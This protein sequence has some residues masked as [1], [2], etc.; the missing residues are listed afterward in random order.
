M[1]RGPLR[2]PPT[3]A[4]R[5]GTALPMPLTTT[6]SPSPSTG[7]GLTGKRATRVLWVHPQRISMALASRQM[8]VGRDDDCALVLAGTEVSRHHAEFRVDGPLVAVRDLGSRNGVFVNGARIADAPLEAGD[9]IRCGEWIGVVVSE[10][11]GAAAFGEITPGWWGGAK[12]AAAVE[13]LRQGKGDLPVIVQGE[14]G[15]GKEGTAHAVHLWSGRKGPFVALNCAALPAELAEAELFGYRKGAFTGA[16]QTSP[17][18]FRAAEGGTLFLDEILELAAPLQAKLLRVLE[19]RRVRALGET[20]DVPI[21]VRVVAATQEPLSDAVAMR[22]FRADLHARLDGLTVVLPPL[23]ERREDIAPLFLELLRQHSGG[24]PPAVETKLVEALCLYD[25][26]LNVRE[27]ALLARRLLNLNGHESVLRK[28]HLPERMIARAVQ[29]GTADGGS[30][31]LPAADKRARR[32]TD[33]QSEFEALIEALRQS[34][35]SVGKAATLVGIS[36]ARAY[37]LIA[38]HPD[39]SLEEIRQ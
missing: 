35:G 20:R 29:E 22:R 15:T 33:D 1:I 2:W 11:A 30:G 7:V 27:L 13:P 37:R 21:D 16:N 25:W 24:R 8:V 19:E 31:P 28:A 26:P 3:L 39:F 5:D 14:T 10:P 9:V 38:A 36:R 18:L 17:G 32:A 34:D 4:R 6:T 23:R 12:L